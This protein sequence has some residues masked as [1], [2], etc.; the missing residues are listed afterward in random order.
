[1]I[2][3]LAFIFIHDLAPEHI[4]IFVMCFFGESQKVKNTVKSMLFQDCFQIPKN[5][6]GKIFGFWEEKSRFRKLFWESVKYITKVGSN[7]AKEK[8]Q[9]AM[10]KKDAKQVQGGVSNL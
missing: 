9:R 4:V 8:L 5:V 1:M 2:N 3:D 7:D 10:R 6:F